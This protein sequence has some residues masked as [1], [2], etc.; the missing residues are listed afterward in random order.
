M[1]IILASTSKTRQALLCNA[2]ITASAVASRVDEASLKKT[3]EGQPPRMICEALA[4][5]KAL[6]VPSQAPDVIVI[7]ADQVLAFEDRIYDKPRSASEAREHLRELRGKTH[8]LISAV[9]CASAGQIVWTYTGTAQ[10]KMREFSDAFTKCDALL[11]PVSPMPAWKL[12]EK[13]NDP[14][15]TYLAD[16][17]TVTA[18]LAGICG[19]SVPCGFTSSKLPVGLQI[20][21]PA[22]R[23]ETIFRVGHAYEQSCPWVKMR[24]G[25]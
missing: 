22:F 5:A 9:A 21:G 15:Q 13:A 19:L 7:G 24:P 6:A 12:G 16:I 8:E 4:A 11:A 1:T 14:L 3:F 18:N 23:E 17:F 25:V 2:G 10:L 20:L